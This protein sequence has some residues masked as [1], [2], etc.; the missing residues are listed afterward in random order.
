MWI[1]TNQVH[2]KQGKGGTYLEHHLPENLGSKVMGDT[3]AGAAWRRVQHSG[4]MFGSFVESFKTKHCIAYMAKEELDGLEQLKNNVGKRLKKVKG[5]LACLSLLNCYC[6][7][8]RSY[9][10]VRA[11]VSICIRCCVNSPPPVSVISLP[12]PIKRRR[13]RRRRKRKV[14]HPLLAGMMAIQIMTDLKP[15]KVKGKVKA[16]ERTK[17]S[18][19][20]ILTR[21]LVL[22]LKV[23]SLHL[24]LVFSQ[25]GSC[26]AVLTWWLQKTLLGKLN[27][28]KSRAV[29]LVNS[30][31]FDE[32]HTHTH[33]HTHKW[34]LEREFWPNCG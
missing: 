4:A 19:V 16:N 27:E 29:V 2:K 6:C 17:V 32:L 34:T 25:R 8:S 3:V 24:V 5:L 7:C 30:D 12:A 18:G 1:P 20:P 10:C 13:R 22:F 21:D 33:T 23:Q 28:G 14:I 15:G 26:A 31:E 11:V 9:M